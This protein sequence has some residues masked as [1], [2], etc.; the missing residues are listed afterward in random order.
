MQFS[1][2]TG[3]STF[4]FADVL[5]TEVNIEKMKKSLS[6]KNVIELS[7]YTALYTGQKTI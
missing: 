5:S 2:Q 4:L 7:S 6:S 3:N 1:T